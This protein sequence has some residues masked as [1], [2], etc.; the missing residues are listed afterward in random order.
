MLFFN[1][2]NSINNVNNKYCY[3]LIMSH[4]PF[5][6]LNKSSEC[7]SE[8]ISCIEYQFLLHIM[9]SL[10][11]N[12]KAAVILPEKFL[13]DST[14]Q[15]K[16]L[17]FEL[18]NY[19]NVECVLSL[20][21]GVMMP[22]SAVKIVILF[23]SKKLSNGSFWLYE[24]NKKEKLNK[25]N[26]IKIE[27]FYDFFD[28][29]KGKKNEEN[30][31]NIN[32]DSLDYSY[33]I[34]E[35]VK[36]N[37]NHNSFSS[38][39]NSNVDL[40]KI[41]KDLKDIGD[42]LNEDIKYIENKIIVTN[43]KYKFSKV[44]VAEVVNS[45]RTAPLS[46]D[47]LLLE[48][49]GSFSV[50]GGNGVIGFFNEFIHSGKFIIVGRVGALCGNIH[51][52]EGNIWVTNNA[53]VLECIDLEQVHPPYLARVLSN[54]NLR[55]LASGTAQPHITVSKV[56]NIEVKLPPFEVQIELEEWLV[57][58]DRKFEEQKELMYQL[59]SKNKSL[60]KELEYH[61]LQI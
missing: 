39:I 11:Q 14:P 48:E 56:K 30:S 51:Y 13:Y 41:N 21:S 45:L 38:F 25:T 17:K 35:Q 23:F 19:F 1:K 54:K 60:K 26:K 20:P 31:W 28:K 44:K 8:N 46:K 34:L 55:D 2:K 42:S 40:N 10:K 53:I 61:L 5:G 37:K 52:V 32:I 50:Y 43:Q 33:N 59:T 15:A 9:S 18:L 47:K 7:N 3:N 6:K 27:D 16:K 24:L 58:L 49:E 4:P 57:K 22:Y 36:N 29:L 12:G